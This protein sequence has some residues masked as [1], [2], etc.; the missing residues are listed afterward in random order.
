MGGKSHV[1]LVITQ[2]A[3][4]SDGESNHAVHQLEYLRDD[5]PDLRLLFFASGAVSRFSRF[6]RDERRDLFTLTLLSGSSGE[7]VQQMTLPVIHRIKE[8]HRRTINHRCGSKWNNWDLGSNNMVE[9]VAPGGK[10]TV[11]QFFNIF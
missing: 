5:A 10:N 4:V 8:V 1:A 11:Y 7:S 6:V 3:A 9:Y 2:L